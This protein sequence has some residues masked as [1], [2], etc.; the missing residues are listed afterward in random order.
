VRSESAASLVRQ[1]KLRMKKRYFIITLLLA[2]IIAA[3][4]FNQFVP[5]KPGLAFAGPVREAADLKFLSDIS[6]QTPDGSR[7]TEQ[8]IFDVNR[9]EKLTPGNDRN[10]YHRSY[11]H[12]LWWG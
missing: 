9:T 8:S 7:I 1:P 6:W 2:A 5:T 4:Y 12:G 10:G 3:Y 11:K